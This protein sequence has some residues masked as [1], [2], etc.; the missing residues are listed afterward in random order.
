MTYMKPPLDNGFDPVILDRYF[1]G[2]CTPAEREHVAAWMRAH[3]DRDAETQ[4]Y[5]RLLGHMRALRRDEGDPHAALDRM[6]GILA[7]EAARRGTGGFRPARAWAI[8]HWGVGGLAA[9]AAVVVVAIGL[10]LG[11][12]VLPHGT[13]AA[14]RTYAT[15]AGQRMSVTLVDGTRFTLAPA[16]RVRVAAGYGEGGLAGGSKTR[17]Y[18]AR[19]VELEGEAYFAVVHDAAHPF[20]VHARGAIARDVGTAFDVRAYADDR[21]VRVA[22]A[23]GRVAL[24]AQAQS[25]STADL[26]AGDLGFLDPSGAVSV[27]RDRDVAGLLVWRQGGLAFDNTPFAD[28]VKDL[29]RTFDLDIA[30]A[31]SALFTNRITSS[32]GD[33]SPDEV[34]EAVSLAVGGRYTRA[35]RRVVIRRQASAADQRPV[36]VPAP[37]IVT[38]R[39]GTMGL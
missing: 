17:P 39:S 29:A 28:V 8:G 5:R 38:A 32:F 25:R 37:G 2:Q 16:S 33:E 24:A 12:L 3:P 31:D 27:T 4:V 34:L 14:S 19:E 11:S 22:V 7:R 35:G 10:S 20:A 1:A 23:E 6:H 18:M 36:T 26:G 21:A 15:A 13:A 9:I 30:V